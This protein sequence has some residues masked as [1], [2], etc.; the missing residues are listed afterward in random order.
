M[1]PDELTKEDRKKA[2]RDA[3]RNQAKEKA[4]ELT[5]YEEYN[6]KKKAPSSQHAE[7]IKRQQEEQK[8]KKAKV[9]SVLPICVISI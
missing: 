4:G 1:E 6:I 5:E 2:A 9:F 7:E 8:Q 3:K